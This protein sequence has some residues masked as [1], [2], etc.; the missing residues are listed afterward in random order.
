VGESLSPAAADLVEEILDHLTKQKRQERQKKQ[1][2]RKKEKAR[3]EQKERGEQ[4]QQRDIGS[5][6]QAIRRQLQ[7]AK[8]QD[9][10]F[11]GFL[12]RKDLAEIRKAAESVTAAL[13]NLIKK[14]STA[15]LL[16]HPLLPGPNLRRLRA[17][18]LIHFWQYVDLIHPRTDIRQYIAA[19]S[20]KDLIAACTKDKLVASGNVLAIARLVYDD[21]F[22][23][24][25]DPPDNWLVKACQNVLKEKPPGIK[26]NTKHPH[27]HD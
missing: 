5:L 15:G 6:R 7:L 12:S 22:G 14:I 23:S 26:I 27:D 11:S 16:D 13:D 1:K 25:P 20:A 9:K 21:A 10:A 3:K 19:R 17:S 4:R 24:P 18:A 2:Q 8:E